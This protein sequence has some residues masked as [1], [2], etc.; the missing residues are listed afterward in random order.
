MAVYQLKIHL[1]GINLHICRRVFVWGDTNLAELHH[2]FQITMSWKNWHLH[3]FKL[4]GKEKGFRMPAAS[5]L[6]TMP[7]GPLEQFP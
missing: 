4:W 5:T 3:S 6:P 1:V 7:P 2:I